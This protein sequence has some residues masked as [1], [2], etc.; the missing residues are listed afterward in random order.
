MGMLRCPACREKFKWDLSQKWPRYCP[1]CREDINNDRPDDEIVM[2]FIRCNGRTASADKLYR[3]MERG[4]EM[5]A[6]MAASML[7][8]SVAEQSSLKITDM[9]DRKDA[10]FA[11]V[12]VPVDNPVGQAMVNNPNVGFSGM[13]LGFSGAVNS[14]A[15][16]NEGL[17]MQGI[18]RAGHADVVG[19]IG[20]VDADTRQPVRLSRNVVF[21]QP[22]NEVNSPGYERRSYDTRS[23]R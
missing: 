22:T 19:Q 12:M 13:G 14:G 2:P 3:D 9:N 4:S 11:H 20:S 21:D 17:R 10:E 16:H 1:L 15:Y 8:T 5:R 23:P 18:L 7:G 6:E